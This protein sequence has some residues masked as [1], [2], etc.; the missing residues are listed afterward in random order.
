MS[1][2]RTVTLLCPFLFQALP[3]QSDPWLQD[4]AKAK[5]QAKAEKKDLLLDF[6]GSDWCSWCIKLDQ[7]VFSQAAFRDATPKD[8]VLVKLDYPNDETKITPEIKAQNE[9][10][11]KQYPIRGYP[12]V[13]L[14]DADGRVYGQTGYQAGGAEKY[15][16]ML[17]EMKKKGVVFQAAMQRADASKGVDRAKALDEAL[18]GLDEQVVHGHH[19]AQM[20]EICRLDADGK[21]ELKAKYE[22]KVKEI[23]AARELETEAQALSEMIGPLM[24]EQ[25]GE[26]ALAK[27][28]E[29]ITAPKSKLQHQLALFFKGMVTMD[30][31]GDA[32]SAV[33]SLEA[34]KA[35]LPESPVAK[36]IEQVLPELK[37]QLEQ[38]KDGGD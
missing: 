29:V 3:A 10:L 34:A 32:K 31:S 36:R 26:K 22:A 20:E 30:V 12:T 17:A 37:K 23:A 33:A 2:L 16:E 8:F 14:A 7:E 28:D 13:L 18:S 11:A 4:F 25:Q 9:Q 27:L 6:T 35:L 15:V 24:Q 1:M 21:A 5:A 38:K 19:L